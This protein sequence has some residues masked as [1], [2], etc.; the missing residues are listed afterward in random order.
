MMYVSSESTHETAAAFSKQY[1]VQCKAYKAEIA[2]YHQVNAAMDQ[3]YQDF[4][5]IDILV[6]NAG[7]VGGGSPAEVFEMES[8]E[9]LFNVNVHG[10]F[11]CVKSAGNHMLKHGKGSI[12][13]ISSV[14]GL[15]ATNPQP[16][17]AYVASKGA[18]T[19]M[20]KSLT[21]EWAPR[22]IRV[23]SINPAYM[24]TDLLKE[25]TEAHPE[26]ANKWKELTP[27]GRL[28]NPDE[29]NGAVVY[30]ASDASSYV[31]GSQI[32]VDGGYTAI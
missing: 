23:N 7:I 19:A 5:K 17:C 31:T 6:A 3:I 14:A 16:Q 28:G 1:N 29:L 15:V 18:V 9:R 2:D 12:I 13:L 26:M 11:N 24:L 8:W 30:L 10:L 22:G 32:Y 25:A 4:G 21:Q 27:M 20:V